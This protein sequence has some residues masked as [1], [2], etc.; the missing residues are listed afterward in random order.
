MC[1]SDLEEKQ[2]P[3]DGIYAVWAWLGDPAER[4][5]GAMSIGARPTFGGRERQLEVFLLDWSGDLVGSEVEVE[6]VE[7]LRA[8]KKFGSAEE[9]VE[10]MKEDVSET[11]R[12][13]GTAVVRPVG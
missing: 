11:R 6:F 7:W 8:E 1:S 5:A 3:A 12:R 9:L 2:V 4:H 10:A 13:L